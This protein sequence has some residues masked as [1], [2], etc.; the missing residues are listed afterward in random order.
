M[1]E[2]AHGQLAHGGIVNIASTFAV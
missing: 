2:L 1:F